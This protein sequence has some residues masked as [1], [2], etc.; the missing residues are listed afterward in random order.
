MAL[1]KRVESYYQLRKEKA[2]CTY[3]VS[4]WHLSE[5][6]RVHGQSIYELIIKNTK[7]TPMLC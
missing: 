4:F 5:L 1:T 2:F 6:T 3:T 7:L